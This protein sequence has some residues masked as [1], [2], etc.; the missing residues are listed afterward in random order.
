M[1]Q[2][3]HRGSF[4]PEDLIEVHTDTL[5]GVSG[6]Q[7]QYYRTSYTERNWQNAT[8][9]LLYKHLFSKE[10]NE[11]TADIN[12]SAVSSRIRGDYNNIYNNRE[13]SIL[14]QEGNTV[15]SIVTSQ[16]DYTGKISDK[17]R[18][19]LGARMSV[20]NYDSAFSNSR[21]DNTTGE[22]V[23]LLQLKT[24]YEYSE[25]IYAAYGNYGHD[26]NKWKVQAGLRIE[27]S[28][29]RAALKDTAVSFRNSY[30]LSLFPSLYITRILNEK[31]D[32]Q[33][34]VNRK[35]SRPSFMELNPFTDYSDSL[36]VTRGNPALKPE[37]TYMG[38]L[39][40]QNTITK[41]NTFIASLYARYQTN[42][43]V[44][45]Q[46]REFN[47]LMGE[48]VIITT[49]A[50]AQSSSSYGLELV[51]KNTLT[52]WF[53]LTSNLNLYNSSINGSNIE[54]KL[55]N[56]FSSWSAKINAGFRLPKNSSLQIMT[57][58][59]SRRSLKPDG[60][61]R[62]GGGGP[63]GG[64]GW[65]GSNNTVQ[66]YIDPV[67]SIDVSLKKDFLK[68]K[69]LT[70]SLSFKDIFRTQLN[71]THSESLYF[72][73]DISRRRDPQFWRFTLSW[74]FGKSDASLFRRKNN[75]QES[76]IMDGG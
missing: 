71:N 51:S 42:L 23:P 5:T 54:S 52:K 48:E 14:Q 24:N 40:Y 1:S 3:F 11:L 12:Y 50:N 60:G 72:T 39:S 21:K 44:R 30:P 25:Y 32:L 38:E 28:D 67:Y 66:G 20:R 10:G 43:T 9:S 62:G 63:G 61:S 36:N 59:S 75:N 37:F 13:P 7:G 29:Y 2:S 26:F 27:S 33:V 64:G 76:D 35:I 58:Y 53:D 47:S 6:E 19:E 41:K 55:K 56:N 34:S 17:T 73:Q 4:N 69:N 74:K 65:G 45:D 57:E 31:Q 22:Y 70:A 49:Y 46:E 16:V 15:Q 68:E 18:L 8:S